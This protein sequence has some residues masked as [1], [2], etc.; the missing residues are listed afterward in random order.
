MPTSVAIDPA[1]LIEAA[2]DLANHQ[3]GRGR[4]RPVFLRRA[5]S[6]A[7][8]ALFHCIGREAAGH[9]L[10]NGSGQEKLAL[11]RSFDHRALKDMCEWIAARRGQPPRH[12]K[13]LIQGLQGTDIG[14]VAAAF[15]DLQ[16]ARHAADYDHLTPVAKTATL[17]HIQDA[18]EALRK[19]AAASERQRETFFAL[20]SLRTG[21]R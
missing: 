2:R 9:L 19:L 4:P 11:A 17:G 18:E 3:G 1:K 15:C 14:D 16:E 6:S 10:P 8:Y 5:T 21:I 12:A 20:V 7:Y 13:V